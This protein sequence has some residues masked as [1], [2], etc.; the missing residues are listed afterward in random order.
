M[1]II[2]FDTKSFYALSSENRIKI[3]KTL[4]SKRMTL[5]ELSRELNLSKTCVKEHLD[6][7][8][9]TGFIKKLDE[10]NRK[11]VYY[12]LTDKGEKVVKNN[13]IKIY[14]VIMFSAL[15]IGSGLYELNKYIKS[16][17]IKSIST[18]TPTP[19]PTTTPIPSTPPLPAE[20]HIIAGV[21]LLITGL[22]LLSRIYSQRKL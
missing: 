19:I 9:D 1:E 4:K 22:F 18:P 21:I 11:W 5:S 12:E 14:I 6:V 10:E 8:I 20:A 17:E 7:L 2:K 13:I 15:I 16:I 3:L